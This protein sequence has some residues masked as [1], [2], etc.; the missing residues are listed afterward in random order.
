MHKD[1]PLGTYQHYKGNRYNVI[2]VARQARHWK[3]LLSTNL[4]MIALNQS[5]GSGHS[6][7]LTNKW[8]GKDK[9][10]NGSNL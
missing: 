7:C 1:V 9:K 6:L 4:F 5:Y 10:C 3:N 8:S 2:G